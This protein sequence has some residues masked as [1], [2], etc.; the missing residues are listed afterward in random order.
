MAGKK[1]ERLFKL[2]NI[3][4]SGRGFHAAELA[5]ALGVSIRTIYRDV[6]ELSGLVP[7]QYDRGYRL[8][9]GAFAADADFT[10]EELL[11]IR[12]G[13]NNRALAA[14]SP[15]AAAA[16]TA[17]IKIDNRL[18]RRF[19]GPEGLTEKI[20]VHVKAHPL[21]E[22][23]VRMLCDL[24]EAVRARRTVKLEYFSLSRNRTTKRAVDPYGLTFR[25][26]SWYLVG[27]CHRRKKPRVFR[28]DRISA[29]KVTRE[30]FEA[31]RDFSLD[32][33]FAD[34]WEVYAS[35]VKSRVKLVF[36]PRVA[37]VV[38]PELEGRGKFY[39]DGQRG[40]LVFE[41]EVPVSEEFRRW[42]LTFG[43]EVEV[44]EPASLRGEVAVTLR[45]AAA[46]YGPGG[47]GRKRRSAKRRVS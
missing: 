40:G 32:G 43:E 11:A 47:P 18:S 31:P 4:R 41:G 9:P 10:R 36:D 24:E 35:A 46:R 27:L 17:L 23:T 26:H 2:V 15:Y 1:T 6:V 29:V 25:R 34:A 39:E 28:A 21:G 12:L 37:P 13:V 30:R 38:R 42:L 8:I 44:L 14:A 16:Q 33:F 5:G 45:T 20:T 22:K 3:L 7:I 19:A